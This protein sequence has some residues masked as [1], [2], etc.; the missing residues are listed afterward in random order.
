MNIFVSK[1][2]FVL[3]FMILTLTAIW[4]S[5]KFFFILIPFLL[6][7]AMSRPLSFLVKKIRNK[8]NLP[9]NLLS[10]IVVIIFIGIFITGI[11]FA[12]YKGIMAL[13]G[14]SDFLSA[15]AQ[16]IQSFTA[17]ASL[18]QLNLPWQEDPIALS[19]VLFQFYDLFIG[20]ISSLTDSVLNFVVSVVKT[21]PSVALFMFF[22]FLSLYFFTKDHDQISLLIKKNFEKIKSPLF[23][24]IKSSSIGTIKNY[25]KAQLILI[26]ITFTISVVGLTILGIPFSPLIALVVALVDLIPMVGPAI[27]YMPWIILIAL[28][29]EYS[30]AIVLL[31]IYL[32]TTLTRQIIEPK[33]VSSKIGTHPLIMLF[34]MYTCYR[35]VGIPGFIIGPI[36]VMTSLVL[37]KSYN[38]T[39][40]IDEH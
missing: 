2:T 30:T 13:R 24:H 39:V 17:S 8:I 4:L 16:N 3:V 25:F 21:I 26:L 12:V 38:A 32:T 9:V 22:M 23:H 6:A 15:I 37:I 31:I 19:D 14:I 28:M 20:T 5:Y 29:S 10:F 34:S 33:I 11:S 35:F 1:I 18:I 7:Y 27:I 36:I 40:K